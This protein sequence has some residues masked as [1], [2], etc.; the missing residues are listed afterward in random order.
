MF[1][2]P[3]DSVIGFSAAA[4]TAILTRLFQLWDYPYQQVE[5]W[6]FVPVNCWFKD[7]HLNYM[8]FHSNAFDGDGPAPPHCK[9]LM[10]DMSVFVIKRKY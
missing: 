5:E 2:I 4:P 10:V 9:V 1:L 7:G 3:V 6:L 8:R